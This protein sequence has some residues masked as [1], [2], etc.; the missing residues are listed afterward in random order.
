MQAPGPLT[1]K[2]FNISKGPGNSFPSDTPRDSIPEINS[3]R[4]IKTKKCF[5]SIGT[6]AGVWIL[7]PDQQQFLLSLQIYIYIYLFKY[8]IYKIRNYINIFLKTT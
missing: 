3:N 8:N 7:A 6:L 2:T 1:E 5:S 4:R